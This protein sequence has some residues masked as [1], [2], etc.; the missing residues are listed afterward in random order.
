MALSLLE[1]ANLSQDKLAPGV[2][3]EMLTVSPMLQHY[4]FI[5]IVGNSLASP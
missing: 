5:E 4:P 2:V 1:S 3:E